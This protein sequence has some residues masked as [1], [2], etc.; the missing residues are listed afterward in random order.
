MMMKVGVRELRENLRAFLEHAKNGGVVVVTERGKPIARLTSTEEDRAYERL[1]AEGV[2]TPAKRPRQP[3]D[4]E[5]LPRLGHPTLT[6][7]LLEQRR[8]SKY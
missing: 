4:F 2:I 7:I 3:I 5:G 1:V 6:D 8:S